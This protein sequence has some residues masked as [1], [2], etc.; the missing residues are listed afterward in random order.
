[1]NEKLL[2]EIQTFEGCI[3]FESIG[4]PCTET[5]EYCNC[6]ALA[7]IALKY[8]KEIPMTNLEQLLTDL[9]AAKEGSLELSDRVLL[10]CGWKDGGSYFT[11]FDWETPDGQKFPRKNLPNPTKSVDDCKRWVEPEADVS[12]NSLRGHTAFQACLGPSFCNDPVEA[13][14]EPL[15]RCAAAIARMIGDTYD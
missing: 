8:C 3:D 14:T 6:Y 10:A 9:K 12:V 1:M 15:A 2:I 5:P 13:T 7:T 11:D 4:V